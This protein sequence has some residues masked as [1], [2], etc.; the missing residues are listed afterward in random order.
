M[1]GGHRDPLATSE[2]LQMQKWRAVSTRE[3]KIFALASVTPCNPEFSQA[4]S[5]RRNL[6]AKS[7]ELNFALPDGVVPRLSSV[8]GTIH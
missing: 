2:K 3:D 8:G 7:A 5:H 6:P 1:L 4:G